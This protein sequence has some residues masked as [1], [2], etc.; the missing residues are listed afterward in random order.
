MKEAGHRIVGER[1]RAQRGVHRTAFERGAGRGFGEQLDC[2]GERRRRHETTEDL[3]Q[4]RGAAR[5]PGGERGFGRC[6]APHLR[7]VARH[8]TGCEVVEQRVH[9]LRGNKTQRSGAAGEVGVPVV[10]EAQR[11]HRLV[12][13]IGGVGDEADRLGELEHPTSHRIHRLLLCDTSVPLRMLR[14]SLRRMRLDKLIAPIQRGWRAARVVARR[15]TEESVVSGQA[16]GRTT[17]RSMMIKKT[18]FHERLEQLNET[19]R[20]GHWSGYASTLK[21]GMSAKHEYFAVRNS[22]GFL[23]T[24]PLYKFRITGRDSERFLA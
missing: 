15:L 21:Y 1:D 9:H 14:S 3:P 7:D 5:Q 17:D 23:D 22:A 19:Y 2:A 6:R 24:S 18:P 8:L 11:V 10:G 12:G 4:S 20:W 13:F 16:R